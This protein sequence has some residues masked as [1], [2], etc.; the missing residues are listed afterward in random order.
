M[1]RTKKD[2]LTELLATA[3]DNVWKNE[4]ALAYNERFGEGKDRDEK[5]KGCRL[6]IEKDTAYIGFLREQ[7]AICG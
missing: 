3:Q 5:E 7:I 6:A 1:E 2:L 4:A